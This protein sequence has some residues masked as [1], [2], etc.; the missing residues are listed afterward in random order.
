MKFLL[1]KANLGQRIEANNL[2]ITVG[3]TFN[4]LLMSKKVI[5]E[6]NSNSI[7]KNLK[8]SPC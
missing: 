4:A 3:V 6:I 1:N 2:G 5:N 7:T 8:D